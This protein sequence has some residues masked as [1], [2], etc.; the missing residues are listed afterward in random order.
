MSFSAGCFENTTPGTFSIVFQWQDGV[1]EDTNGLGVWGKVEKDGLQVAESSVVP[2][3]DGVALDLNGVPNGE[4]LV[5]SVELKDGLLKTDHT[6]YYG[7]SETF[8][9]QPG[10]H[11]EVP[12]LLLI[13]GAPVVPEIDTTGQTQAIHFPEATGPD[14]CPDC[15]TNKRKVDVAFKAERA[16]QVAI[17]N[18]E[19]FSETE[20]SVFP[21]DTLD[22]DDQGYYL[23]PDWELDK[24]Q[25]DTS[26]G[27]RTVFL[28]LIDERGYESEVISRE[29]I[30][31]TQPPTEA[32]ITSTTP[33]VVS[34]SQ[35]DL[36]AELVFAVKSAD[37][38]LVQ[39]CTDECITSESIIDDGIKTCQGNERF[40]L[41]DLDG[42]IE[43][44]TRG[45]VRLA[46]DSVKKVLVKFRDFAQNNTGPVHYEFTNVSAGISLNW[47]NIPDGAFQMGCATSLVQCGSNE[48]PP[49]EVTVQAFDMSVT[50][51]TQEQFHAVT[52]KR[53][54][55]FE[56]CGGDCPVEQVA[57]FEA[58]AFCELVGGR[59]PSEAEWE[60][61]ARAGTE[62]IWSCGDDPSCLN[63]IA[64]YEENSDNKT[65]PV[66]E[67]DPNAFGLYD[68]QGNV[69]EWVED[70]WNNNY[71]GAPSTG[72]VWGG[73]DCGL[74][75]LRGGCYGT[76]AQYTRASWRVGVTQYIT[77]TDTGFRCARDISN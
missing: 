76:F 16:V 58:K 57:W 8:R 38:M 39:A 36:L 41:P 18:G 31:D 15:Y 12:V 64:W 37:E 1:P 47:V 66:A 40:C 19:G 10:Q 46:D 27:V 50:E 59:L 24:G 3:T 44:R 34:N 22:I 29:L 25:I 30:L 54:S 62:T 56:T 33:I 7:Q 60:Y 43:F 65:H 70:C 2:Y 68:M 49:H 32:A 42:W 23:I 72:D 14:S 20:S 45:W 48:K 35:T 52:G 67:K 26:D 77:S 71:D 63:N 4:N 74:R 6:L 13:V 69:G 55:A 28:K 51:I 61:A 11:V 17:S 75:V 53:P 73:G 9:L 5:V 21:L